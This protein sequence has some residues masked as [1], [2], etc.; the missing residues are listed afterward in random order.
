MAEKKIIEEGGVK[1]LWKRKI[2]EEGGVKTLWKRI[3]TALSGKADSAHTHTISQVTS[4]QG[5]L[6]SKIEPV[7]TVATSYTLPSIS[8]GQ[9]KMLSATAGQYANQ[10]IRLPSGGTYIVVNFA[11]NL[12]NTIAYIGI[13][14]G[15]AIVGKPHTSGDSTSSLAYKGFYI[16]IS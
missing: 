15:G 3:R 6:D 5:E 10:E 4:L 8:V 2:I 14:S 9:M 12:P 1:T 13:Y 7:N 11:F 16:R